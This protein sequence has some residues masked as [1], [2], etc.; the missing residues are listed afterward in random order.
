MAMTITIINYTN[1]KRS[2]INNDI[3][4]LNITVLGAVIWQFLWTRMKVENQLFWVALV[5]I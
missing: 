5:T 2:N 1:I 4:I 3:C